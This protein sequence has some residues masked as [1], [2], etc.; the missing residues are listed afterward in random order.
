MG[1][2]EVNYLINRPSSLNNQS[3]FKLFI[4]NCRNSAWR[5]HEASFVSIA[6]TANTLLVDC[7]IWTA[8]M[9][10]GEE[11]GTP[12]GPSEFRIRYRNRIV[13]YVGSIECAE[14]FKHA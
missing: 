8:G 13:L 9:D 3:F 4:G 6:K 10:E 1:G 5:V 14:T 11:L 2:V 12:F 7:G